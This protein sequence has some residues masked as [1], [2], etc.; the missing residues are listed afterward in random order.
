MMDTC[1]LQVLPQSGAL[2]RCNAEDRLKWLLCP[3]AHQPWAFR[4]A[5]LDMAIEERQQPADPRTIGGCH[6]PM[7]LMSFAQDLNTW[8][9]CKA[10]A[11]QQTWNLAWRR[12]IDPIDKQHQATLYVFFFQ[13]HHL[14]STAGSS[15]IVSCWGCPILD[16]RR[17]V[18][19]CGQCNCWLLNHRWFQGEELCNAAFIDSRWPSWCFGRRRLAWVLV[20]GNLRDQLAIIS[21]GWWSKKLGLSSLESPMNQADGGMTSRRG[22]AG[23]PSG[24]LAMH[25]TFWSS[26]YSD[27]AQKITQSIVCM[28][29]EK[30]LFFAVSRHRV[31]DI[32]QSPASAKMTADA[33]CH[34]FW[35]CAVLFAANKK[36]ALAV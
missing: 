15:Q 31:L 30:R 12:S 19:M 26:G 23:G 28:F 14:T 22:S 29:N 9:S 13:W 16:T 10:V 7:S 21:P 25:W 34:F 4:S 6:F 1:T 17:L 27:F 24:R 36:K 20:S 35:T 11:R 5:R 8:W 32:H 18:Q 33:F 3:S 2:F